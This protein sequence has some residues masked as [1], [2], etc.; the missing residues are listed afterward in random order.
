L[1][2]C[3]IDLE[4]TGLEF[5]KG[6]ELLELGFV[7]MDT[8]LF[9]TPPVIEQHYCKVRGVPPHITELTG[10]SQN[11]ATRNGAPVEL[12]LESLKH[13]VEAQKVEYMVA[14]NG[15]IFD[16]P[17]LF[18]VC[19]EHKFD[20]QNVFDL[21]WIDTAGDIPEDQFGTRSLT[22]MAAECGFINPFPHSAVFDCLTTAKVL[23]HVD[24]DTVIARSRD[25]WI[26]VQAKVGYE[27]RQKAKDLKFRWQQAGNSEYPKMWVKRIKES[28]FD[29]LR[30]QAGFDVIQVE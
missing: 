3:F 12:A 9:R 22:Y 18:D 19:Y 11:F 24:L 20:L 13:A 23:S 15:E 7:I 16:Q 25:P 14:H 29:S 21:P 17:F 1:K 2:L 27:D 5:K 4:T 28:D 26:V 8:P 30:K 6:A 10:I